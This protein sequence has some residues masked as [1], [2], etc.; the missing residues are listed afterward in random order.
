MYA[1]SADGLFKSPNLF[2]YFSLLI[3]FHITNLLL[4]KC[5]VIQGYISLTLKVL[6][7]QQ[8]PLCS[9]EAGSL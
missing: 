2:I 6:V 1:A 5:V 8:T 4:K 9:T 3:F 7:F